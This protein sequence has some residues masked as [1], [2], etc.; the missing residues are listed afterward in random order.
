MK[1]RKTSTWSAM[2]NR[3]RFLSGFHF[4]LFFF[5]FFFFFFFL[6]FLFFFF[7]KDEIPFWSG[8]FLRVWLVANVTGEYFHHFPL[9][10]STAPY[11]PPTFP[12]LLLSSP[13]GER[14][15]AEDLIS[16]FY[17]RKTTYKT[18]NCVGVSGIC[19]S[20]VSP[21]GRTSERE[22]RR[23]GKNLIDVRIRSY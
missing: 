3:W 20:V 9:L 21:T 15:H 18:L 7:S 22:T 12:L 10:L 11:P 17:L 19:I 23:E 16:R 4:F 1:W 2:A 13:I 14:K 5:F 8:C 6:F